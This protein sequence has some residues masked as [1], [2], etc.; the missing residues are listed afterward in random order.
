MAGFRAAAKDGV[1]T[2]AGFG[3]QD[4]HGAE[5]SIVDASE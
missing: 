3:R 1:A 2:L 4:G 5:H